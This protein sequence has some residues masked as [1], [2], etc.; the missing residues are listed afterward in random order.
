M[1]RDE[2][3]LPVRGSEK[4]TRWFGATRAA[5]L[6]IVARFRPDPMPTSLF[7]YT[8]TS[9]L[10][11]IVSNNELWLSDA[12]FLNDRV[13]IEHGRTVACAR[14]N[15]AVAAESRVDVKAMLEA[16]L[17]NFRTYSDPVVYV[18]C[19][20]LE[21]DDLAQWR[22]YGQGEAPIAIGFAV[23]GYMFGYTS[24][25]SL[26]QA[27]YELDEQS[28]TFDQVVTA[29]ASTYAEDLRDPRPNPQRGPIPPEEERATCAH[30]LYHALWRYIVL[31]K[32]PAFRSEREV[33]FT[34]IAHD[35]SRTG[36]DWHP[37]HPSPK[38]RERSGRIIP[39][40]SSTNL[41]FA[42]MKRAS[43]APKLPIRSVHIGPTADQAVVARGV[44]RLLD[45]Y[46]HDAVEVTISGTPVRLR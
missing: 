29:Y 42:N 5:S 8:S 30:M 32:N 7:H 15:E 1:S 36:R 9:A 45:A 13:E 27:R 2:V 4:M 24:E 35:L 18:A 33:R 39:Y 19:F 14:L 46:G 11:S 25:G 31:C 34:Y 10:I 44:R 38:F 26:D 3:T 17:T 41:D 28:W 12:T 22:G 21:G 23:D 37:E 16:T 6:A 20:S 43:E 40:L